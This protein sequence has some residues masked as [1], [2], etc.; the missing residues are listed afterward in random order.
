MKIERKH[1]K[2][3]ELISGFADLGNDGV[4]G[5]SGKLD[6]R[7][8]YQREFIYDDKKQ[9]AVIDSVMNGFPLGIKYFSV[10]A[11]GKFEVLD[12]QQRILSICHFYTHRFSIE[13]RNKK[14][15]YF[16]GLTNDEKEQFLNY[17]LDI[18]FCE[19]SESEKLSWFN[20]INIAGE[21]L[22]QQELRNASYT[23]AW[24]AS[25]KSYFSKN[26][27]PAEDFSNLLSGKKNR[28]DW[29]ETVLRWKA[30]DEDIKTI[31]EF[32]AKNQQDENARDLWL[33]FFRVVNWVNQ[34]FPKYRSEM[35]GVEWGLIYNQHKEKLNNLDPAE[36]EKQVFVLMEDEEIRNK[37]GIYSYIFS[38]DEADLR[39]RDFTSK[40]KSEIKANAKGICELCNKPVETEAEA[41]YDHRTPWSKGGKTEVSNGA[42]VHRAC[43]RRKSD[44]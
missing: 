43:N 18:Y 27:A 13:D 10:N 30:D 1:I 26:G 44:K 2:I 28:Q 4:T 7:P 32:M 14:T 19:G 40:Q 5:L 38:H 34:I 20:R 9:K 3:K 29:L 17:E 33:Y 37:K 6:I 35:K 22:T 15:K 16:D 12:G 36:V 41:E 24:L 21:P 25:A 42:Y 8:P 23:G 11:P 39:L 31:E